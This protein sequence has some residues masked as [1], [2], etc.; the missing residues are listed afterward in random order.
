MNYDE[1]MK[2][3]TQ[4]LTGDFDTD[5]QYLMNQ[6][7][8]YK[9][10]DLGKEIVRACGRLLY[11]ILP[12]DK[13]E[14]IARVMQTDELGVEATLDEVRFNIYKKDYEKADVLMK[15]LVTKVED[16]EKSGMFQDDTVSMYFTFNGFFEELLYITRNKPKKDVRRSEIP[17]AEIYLQ[18]GS[19][20]FE[21]KRYEEAR[22][23]LRKAMRWNPCSAQ[24][25]FE[26]A[27]TYKVIGDLEGFLQV[28][29][30]TFKVAYTPDTVARCYRN[31]AFYFVEKELWSEAMACNLMSLQYDHNSP[32]A[33][34]E[35]YYIQQKT[36]GSV[37]EPGVE[38]LRAYSEKYGFPLGADDDILGI[39]Y[40]YGRRF[41]ED[42]Q[43]EAAKYFFTIL[44]N[45]TDDE[46]IKN[47]I[48]K[49]PEK[50]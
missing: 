22:E 30:N 29:I 9:D 48:D 21:L 31:L 36:N 41:L 19:L 24:I 35:M 1:I 25:A 20:L 5:R 50:E 39:A 33:M 34:S 49:I 32:N 42:E 40:G 8:N 15:A 7:E 6:M 28:S 11:S 37:P 17:F 16:L 38:E 12:E 18:Y 2:S 26:Y 47:I 27:E 4:G 43:Y 13:K 10:H 46:E 23:M 44:Y 14:E 45:L 3:I